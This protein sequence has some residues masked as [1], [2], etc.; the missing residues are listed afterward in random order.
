MS[1]HPFHNVWW[2]MIQRC[3]DTNCSV[4]GRYGGRGITVCDRWMVFLNFK[5]DMYDSWK[6]GLQLDRIDNDGPYS[7]ENCRWAT[8]KQQARNRRSNVRGRILG[9]EYTLADAVDRFRV[10][11]YR[12]AA[13][14]IRYGWDFARAVLIP[15][16]PYR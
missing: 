11:R 9:H 14:R 5:E 1:K 7:P 2:G 12:I 4:Y 16:S 13:D 3:T 10:V 15:K 8:A 6:R